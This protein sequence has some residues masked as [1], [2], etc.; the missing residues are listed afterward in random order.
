MI[1]VVLAL[2]LIG[3][4]ALFAF[5]SHID[6]ATGR[7]SPVTFWCDSHAASVDLDKIWMTRCVREGW[8][9]NEKEAIPSF[10]MRR[11]LNASAFVSVA[12]RLRDH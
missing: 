10:L 12:N 8:R 1:D 6:P 9:A 4:S 7:F 3:I 2:C 11:G 5:A